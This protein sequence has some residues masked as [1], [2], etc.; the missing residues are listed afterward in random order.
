MWRPW[1]NNPTG[2]QKKP[3]YEKALKDWR[4]KKFFNNLK[5]GLSRPSA[6]AMAGMQIRTVYEWFDTIP[7]FRQEV[8]AHEEMRIWLVENKKATLISKG[9]RPAIEKELRSKKREIYGD[10][11]EQDTNIKLDGEIRIKMPWMLE[12]EDGIDGGDEDDY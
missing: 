5:T 2:A 1:K 11:I 9:Y 3:E 7:N 12:D 6:I 10:K 8:E 4:M